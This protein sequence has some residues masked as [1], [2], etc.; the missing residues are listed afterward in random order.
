[1]GIIY[2]VTNILNGKVY[3]G[4]TTQTLSARKCAHA[5]M[6]KKGDRRT[7]FQIALLDEGFDNFSWEKRDEAD[8]KEA[9]DEKEKYW[10]EHYD[11][12]NPDKGYNNQSGGVHNTP[13]LAARK[14]M[15]E[16]QKGN[17]NKL[18][19]RH[20]EETRRKQSEAKSGE[21]HPNYGKHH[22][23]ETL[24]K[25]SEVKRGKT[26]SEEHRRK[27]KEARNKRAPVSEETRRKMSEAHKK[28][29]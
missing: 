4:Q 8:S 25:M 27:L 2:K 28:H 11:S 22:S 9:L 7:P 24:K 20:N 18:G 3:I 6:A 21:N 13:S 10:I 19:K 15:S 1:M 23:A 17:K 26:F 12:M 29:G 14:K 5:F 16:V